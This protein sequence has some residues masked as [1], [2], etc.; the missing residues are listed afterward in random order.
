MRLTA[1]SYQSK[2]YSNIKIQGT[3]SM[4]S[5]FW[6]LLQQH[7]ISLYSTI[8]SDHSKE[9]AA[10][11]PSRKRHTLTNPR[12]TP[13]PPL[14]PHYNAKMH[15]TMVP[16]VLVHYCAPNFK[17]LLKMLFFCSCCCYEGLTGRIAKL[18]HVVHNLDIS[19]NDI[20]WKSEFGMYILEDAKFSYLFIDDFGIVLVTVYFVNPNPTYPSLPKVEN[21]HITF[22][23]I[24]GGYIFEPLSRNVLPAFPSMFHHMLGCWK[25]PIVHH[26]KK[27]RRAL[28]ICSH[29]VLLEMMTTSLQWLTLG[30]AITAMTIHMS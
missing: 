29:F 16:L 18:Y 25:V 11:G 20:Q 8:M 27:E 13:T 19:V 15:P 2:T 3:N 21:F 6:W 30:S 28:C 7:I 5:F 24:A 4:E 17:P 26:I 10:A 12:P 22:A 23:M 14:N 9:E 1:T